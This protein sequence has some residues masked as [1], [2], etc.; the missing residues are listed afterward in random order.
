MLNYDYITVLGPTASGKTRFAANLAVRINAEIISA[1]SRQVYRKMNIGT[2]KDYKDYI[3]CGRTVASHLL[4]IREPG[5]HYNLYEFQSDFLDAYNKIKNGG[6]NVILCGGTGMYIESVLKGYEIMQ[7]PVNSELRKLLER[8]TIGEL[9]SI[10]SSY[11]QLHNVS[12]TSSRPRLIRAIEIEDYRI[13]SQ[14]E[15]N[16]F[17]RFNS[18]VLGINIGREERRDRITRRLASRMDEGMVEEVKGLLSAGLNADEIIFYGLEYKYITLFLIGK[19]TYDEM[20]L[21]L[22]SA[23]HQFA[24]RQMTWF[25]KMERQGIKIHWLKSSDNIPEMVDRAMVLFESN[26]QRA[27]N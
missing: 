23:I 18:F 2:G 3:V 1:D 26:S 7:V 16:P 19:L 20:F 24:K 10:L 5:Y 9:S 14:I 27:V 22:N 6:R 17:P 4:D 21:Q 12:D 15:K 11:K 25:R 8:K 13:N